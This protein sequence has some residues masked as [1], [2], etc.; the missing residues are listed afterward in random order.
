MHEFGCANNRVDRAGLYAERAPDA[1]LFINDG[2][3]QGQMLA[4]GFVKWQHFGF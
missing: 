2:D 1:I 3:L 4:T